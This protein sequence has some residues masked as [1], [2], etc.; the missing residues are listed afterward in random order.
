[1]RSAHF[2]SS[3]G[4]GGVSPTPPH[5]YRPHPL[6]SPPQDAEPPDAPCRQTIFLP[7]DRQTPVKILPCLKLRFRAVINKN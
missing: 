6:G 2:S 7:I 3:G 4:G 1:M 5:G